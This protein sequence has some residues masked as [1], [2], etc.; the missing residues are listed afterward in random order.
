MTPPFNNPEGVTVFQGAVWVSNNGGTKP[1]KTL[2]RLVKNP[3]IA[4]LTPSVFGTLGSPFSCPGGMF[5]AGVPGT[6]L[7]TL[8]VNDEGY[9]VPDTHCGSDD[10]DQ[11]DQIGRVLGFRPIDLQHQG[12]PTPWH[13]PGWTLTRTSSPGFG[14]IFVQID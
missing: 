3:K 7:N 9:G 13:F 2:V 8:W 12:S 6:P 1:G 4:T 11:G 5:A 14:G 10:T